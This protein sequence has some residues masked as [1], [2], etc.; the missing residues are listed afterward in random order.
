[1]A[2]VASNASAWRAMDALKRLKTSGGTPGG[3]APGAMA[4]GKTAAAAFAAGFVVGENRMMALVA[5]IT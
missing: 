5:M 3:A 2:V 4:G 1:M